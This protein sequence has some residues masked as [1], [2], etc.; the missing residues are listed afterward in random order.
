MFSLRAAC[1]GKSTGEL[2]EVLSDWMGHQLWPVFLTLRH[3]L[4][5]QVL[6][7]SATVNGE[8]VCVHQRKIMAYNKDLNTWTQWGHISGGDVYSRPYS[9][10]GFVCEGIG[11]SLYVIGGTREYMQHRRYCTPLNTVEICN[12]D[13]IKQQASQIWWKLGADMGHCRGT[14]SASTVLSL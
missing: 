11:S 7:P 6:G 12:L 5:V 8:L 4:T 9:R 10:F 1:I 3:P 13:G 2:L 14:M